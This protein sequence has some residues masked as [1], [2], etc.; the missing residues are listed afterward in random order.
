MMPLF[1]LLYIYYGFAIKSYGRDDSTKHY[2]KYCTFH[3]LYTIMY[4]L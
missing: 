2:L 3:L 1:L 4:T